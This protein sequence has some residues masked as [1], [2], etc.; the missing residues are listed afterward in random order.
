VV[1]KTFLLGVFHCTDYIKDI[2]PS[3]SFALRPESGFAS[4]GLRLVTQ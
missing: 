2:L 3:V 1:A 4:S